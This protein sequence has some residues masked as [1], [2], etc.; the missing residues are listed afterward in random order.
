MD[1]QGDDVYGDVNAQSVHAQAVSENDVVSAIDSDGGVPV[2]GKIVG[3]VL[4]DARNRTVAPP[5]ETDL[6]S[7]R[8]PGHPDLPPM[9]DASIP[10]L[11][12]EGSFNI[13]IT[14][15]A[16]SSAGAVAQQSEADKS[17]TA[18]AS[19]AN[20]FGTHELLL[21]VLCVGLLV[22]ITALVTTLSR[23]RKEIGQSFDAEDSSELAR[24]LPQHTPAR[25]RL[26]G[27]STVSRSYGATGAPAT[28]AVELSTE[29]PEGA[30][31]SAIEIEISD[32]E[33]Q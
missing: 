7:F 20:G 16:T 17:E 1:T 27:G 15:D 9:P 3:A 5:H 13:D 18:D 10:F 31:S 22:A 12:N 23:K 30:T 32:D 2:V 11:G 6:G 25:G 24:L 19:V 33:E 28:E 14:D 8:P 21:P 4:D 29:Y 26:V